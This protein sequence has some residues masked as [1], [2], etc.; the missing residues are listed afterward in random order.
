M[1]DTP[2]YR[3]LPIVGQ[4][5][6]LALR[7]WGRRVLRELPPFQRYYQ[8]I[9]LTQWFSPE[10]LKRWQLARLR[11]TLSDAVKSVPF[12]R[13]QFAR[14]GTKPEDIVGTALWEQVPFLTKQQVRD[15]LVSEASPVLRFRAATSG[16]TGTSLTIYQGLRTIQREH[17]FLSRQLA[18]A[19]VERRD[20]RAWLRGDRIVP[21]DQTVPPFWRS[22]R[23]ERMMMFSSFHLKKEHCRKYVRQL[24]RYDPHAINAHPSSITYLARYLEAAGM[25]YGGR[26]LK[27][28]LTSSESLS[29][30]HRVAIERHFG[31]PVFD[32]YG[33]VERVAAIGTCDAGSYHLLSDYGFAELIPLGDDRAEIVATSFNNPV[34]PLI[35]YRTGDV[36]RLPPRGASCTCGRAFPL[37]AAIEGRSY[38]DHLFTKDGRKVHVLSH[39]LREATSIIE[40]QIVQTQLGK[41]HIYVV[42]QRRLTVRARD[43]IIKSAHAHLG[44]DTEVVVSEVDAIRRGH[45]GKFPLVINQIANHNR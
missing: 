30:Q 24:E 8:E 27:A 20:R 15:N 1:Y 41:I 5:M 19:G 37:I 13:E 33:S 7:G 40:A 28:V 35:R 3:N 17:A 12:Y 31:V 18:W 6:L 14:F 9:L 44:S 38:H 26:N 16:T 42:P 25:K 29:S 4:E 11:Q 39:I 23:G 21:V 2:P 32:W 22:N 43:L 36:V 45:R 10:E 34:M